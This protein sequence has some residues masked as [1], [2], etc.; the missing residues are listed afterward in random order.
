MVAPQCMPS[1][2]I[3]CGIACKVQTAYCVRGYIRYA[4]RAAALVLTTH[5]LVTGGVGAPPPGLGAIGL[6]TWAT[7]GPSP[8][9]PRITSTGLVAQPSTSSASFMLLRHRSSTLFSESRRRG[10]AEQGSRYRA[11]DLASSRHRVSGHRCSNCP[12]PQKRGRPI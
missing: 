10:R 11:A 5:S 7:A 2:S 1:R 4:P 9:S 6:V 8:W 12:C 3:M